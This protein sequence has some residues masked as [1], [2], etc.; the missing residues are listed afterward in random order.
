ML[1]SI[2]RVVVAE[3]KPPHRHAKSCFMVVFVLLQSIFRCAS[4]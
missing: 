1:D 4:M 2:R 3:D